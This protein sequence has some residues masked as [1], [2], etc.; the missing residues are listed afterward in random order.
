MLL[1]YKYTYNFGVVCLNIY[2]YIYIYYIYIY[3]YMPKLVFL[4]HM[5]HRSVLGERLQQTQ[6]EIGVRELAARLLVLL[7]SKWRTDVEDDN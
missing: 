1:N 7:P 2:I 6:S 3:I 5:N 4:N